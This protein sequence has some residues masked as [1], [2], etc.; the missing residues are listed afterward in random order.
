MPH[1]ESKILV[2]L[3]SL[4]W[5]KDNDFYD[6]PLQ[7]RKQPITVE[8]LFKENIVTIESIKYI[9]QITVKSVLCYIFSFIIVNFIYFFISLYLICFYNFRN[10]IYFSLHVI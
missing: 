10:C 3:I 9:G 8:L 6:A 5:R 2:D 4:T 1:N 7:P